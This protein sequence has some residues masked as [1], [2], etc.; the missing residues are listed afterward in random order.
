MDIDQDHRTDDH[1]TDSETLDQATAIK[2]CIDLTKETLEYLKE[3][4]ASKIDAGNLRM[5]A[6]ARDGEVV[7]IYQETQSKLG[8]CTCC[9]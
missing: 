9:G 7:R 5:R 4:Q 3:A 1:N 2:Q 6:V 8:E